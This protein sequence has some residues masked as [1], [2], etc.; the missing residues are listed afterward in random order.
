MLTMFG[1][2][3]APCQLLQLVSEA[4]CQALSRLDDWLR[5]S[6]VPQAN[7]CR[8]SSRDSRSILPYRP[9]KFIEPTGQGLYISKVWVS[10]QAEFWIASSGPRKPRL[11]AAMHQCVGSAD[12]GQTS[13]HVL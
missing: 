5:G 3:A 7:S 4:A 6:S 10:S 11:I 8:Y 9:L 12:M 13:N 1:R 2:L